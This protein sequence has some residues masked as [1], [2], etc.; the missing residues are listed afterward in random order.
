[1]LRFLLMTSLSAILST[2]LARAG[3]LACKP[4]RDAMIK[5]YSIPVH[6]YSTENA[7]YTG[8]KVRSSEIVYLNN[9]SYV[10]V[11][12]K[13]RTSPLTQEKIQEIRKDEQDK[14]AKATCS[15]VREESVNGESAVLYRVH[16]DTEDV[17]IDSQVWISKQRAVPLKAEIDMDVGGKLGKSHRSM[18]YE[19]TNVQAPAGVR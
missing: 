1:M 5:L 16:Q 10:H 14:D 3:N 19:Y 9:S 15:V 8:G 11:N 7:A 2:P 6:I 17:K 4:M 12:G 13:W 18:R